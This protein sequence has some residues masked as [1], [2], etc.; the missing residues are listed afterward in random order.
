MSEE[1]ANGDR[2]NPMVGRPHDRLCKVISYALWSEIA[3][4]CPTETAYSMDI[5]R[6]GA[7]HAYEHD[8]AFHA[9]VHNVVAHVLDAAREFYTPN[10]QV[11]APSGARSAE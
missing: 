6:E 11:D 7:I 8:N 10:D 5:W 1:R 9:K 4:P 2:L 3:G